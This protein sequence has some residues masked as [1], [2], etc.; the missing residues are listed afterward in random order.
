MSGPIFIVSGTRPEVIK[1]FPVYQQLRADKVDVVW[2]ASGQHQELQKQALTFFGVVAD[3]VLQPVVAGSLP[4]QLSKLLGQLADLFIFQRPS[5]VIVQGDTATAL[6]AAMAAFFLQIKVAYVEAGLRSFDL[7]APFPEEAN[8]QIIS[9]LA[10]LFFAPTERDKNNL[11]AEGLPPDKVIVTGNTI[12][13]ALR[14]VCHQL[15]RGDS[16]ATPRLRAVV[17]DALTN[18]R[19]LFVFTMHRRESL[20]GLGEHI[21]RQV[22]SQIFVPKPSF[23]SCIPGG[24]NPLVIY[25]RHLNPSFAFVADFFEKQERIG[26]A[27]VLPPLDYKDTVFLIRHAFV[28][29]TDSG[30]ILEEAVSLGKPVVCLREKTERFFAALEKDVFLIGPRAQSFGMAMKMATKRAFEDRGLCEDSLAMNVTNVFG[31]GQSA[32]KIVNVLKKLFESDNG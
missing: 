31:D 22:E 20:F 5:I 29:M 28:V 14:H 16:Q 8:R 30:G 24:W 18:K 3:H 10:T 11:I 2:V 26:N 12:V 13:D 6:A 32:L 27:L 23:V 15:D 9:R 7:E 19:Q 17:A 4:D 21:L 25:L 1:L